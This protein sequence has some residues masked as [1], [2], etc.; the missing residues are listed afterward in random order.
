MKKLF[1]LFVAALVAAPAFAQV[2]SEDIQKQ[3]ESKLTK[4]EFQAISAKMASSSEEAQKNLFAAFGELERF[5]QVTKQENAY[6]ITQYVL[7]NLADPLAEL[8]DEDALPKALVYARFFRV[9]GTPLTQFVR[10]HAGEFRPKEE[11]ELRTFAARVDVLNET[12]DVNKVFKNNK[13][14]Y[15]TAQY[16]LFNIVDSSEKVSDAD[17]AYKAVYYKEM[18]VGATP[19][20]KF[21]ANYAD[22]LGFESF[23]AFISRVQALA[24]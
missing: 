16:I 11:G 7:I 17:F 23:D 24:K 13:N 22:M 9:N 12:A 4:A 5:N 20:L 6:F 2:K 3:V 21:M 1:V 14:A 15:F 8:S 10:A 19:L 18:K